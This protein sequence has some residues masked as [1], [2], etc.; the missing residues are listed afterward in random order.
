MQRF[1]MFN[2]DGI[3]ALILFVFA[4]V[5]YADTNYYD[6][7]TANA[8]SRM[9]L[10]LSLVNEGHLSI[11]AFAPLTPD[12][13]LV[14]GA[15]YS[16][17][18]PGLAFLSLPAAVASRLI[19]RLRGRDDGLD[20]FFEDGHLSGVYDQ[21]AYLATLS[22]SVLIGALG[23]VAVFGSSRLLGAGRAGA[24]FAALACGFGSPYWGWATEFLG[25]TP[26]AGLLALAVWVVL[27]IAR[28]APEVR[29]G[30]WSGALLGALLGLAA[31][32]EYP[33]VPAAGMIGLSGLWMAWRRDSARLMS[34]AAGALAAGLLVLAPTLIY[35]W[36][37]FGSPFSI[38]YQSV[39]GFDAMRTGVV[40]VSLP[41]V[42]IMGEL[43]FGPYRGLFWVA[44]VLLALPVA[45]G[46]AWHRT[47][48][49]PV[50]VAMMLGALSLLAI[51]SGYAY[52][53]GDYSTGPRHLITTIP[54]LAMPL[55]VLFTVAGRGG[56]GLLLALLTVSIAVA[57][58]CT[59]IDVISPPEYGFPLADYLLPRL[60]AGDFPDSISS[61]ALHLP[62][63]ARLI[64]TVVALI[65]GFGALTLA[66]VTPTESRKVA[67]QGD[68]PRPRIVPQSWRPR[69]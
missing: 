68:Q 63:F 22:T 18:A 23:V 15:Y 25:H 27:W 4:F 8:V 24:V 1:S 34:T 31:M 50:L 6:N 53:H 39:V 51:N 19:D 55:G 35:N 26:T 9:G 2:R 40:G 67:L 49:R 57:L 66:V 14:D 21:V 65:I 12:K 62:G 32:T 37:A 13:S 54:L 10:V 43:L 3:V 16:D 45:L 30:L 58:V 64:P 46:V 52:W 61:R 11:D 59:R 36:K 20:R 42:P 60:M 48:S 33:V 56:R 69:V 7:R 41:R 38:G 47:R 5:S 28:V 29:G 44:P 17:K